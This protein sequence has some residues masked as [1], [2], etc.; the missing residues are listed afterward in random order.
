MQS[1]F[2][3]T[4]KKILDIRTLPAGLDGLE[5]GEIVFVRGPIFTARAGFYRRL[6]DEGLQPEV[7]LQDKGYL[8]LFHGGPAVQQGPEGGWRIVSLVPMPD[9]SQNR[10]NRVLKLVEQLGVRVVIGKGRMP[11]TAKLFQRLGAVHL[12]SIGNWADFAAQI[13]GV[14]EI[15]WL[16]LGLTDATWVF[17]ANG[18]GPFVVETDVR[19]N[20][21]YDRLDPER[22]SRIGRARA[23][24]GR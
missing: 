7:R 12:A 9:V 2:D 22:E 17:E 4:G 23:G 24:R 15:G 5:V 6:L 10:D 18:M 3:P 20:S 21:L 11:G 14:L 8:A 13:D 1:V 19:G 16:D